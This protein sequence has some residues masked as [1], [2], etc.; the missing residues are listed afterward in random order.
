MPLTSG[1]SKAIVRSS[2][3]KKR[4]GA[5]QFSITPPISGKSVW[6]L[7]D[8][9]PLILDGGNSTTYTIIPAT[10]KLVSIKMWGQG[11]GGCTGGYS[12]GTLYADSSTTYTIQLNA[13]RGSG[14][15]GYGWVGN[16]DPGGGGQANGPGPAT[17]G[18]IAGKPGTGGG[19][20][21]ANAVGQSPHPGEGGKGG[22]G[23]VLIAYPS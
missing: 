10:S 6:N 4:V 17:T 3:R 2:S 8:D 20:G 21:G 5:T 7:E 15:T 1:F 11:G 12:T 9:G 13:G 18:P 23:I 19:G 14:G 22:S 16:G